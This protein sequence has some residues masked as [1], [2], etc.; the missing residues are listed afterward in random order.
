MI[1]VPPD[2]PVPRLTLLESKRNQYL[3]RGE[4]PVCLPFKAAFPI[5]LIEERKIMKFY[6]KF[7]AGTQW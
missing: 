2:L 1:Y 7:G 6:L 4:K 3:R 5:F